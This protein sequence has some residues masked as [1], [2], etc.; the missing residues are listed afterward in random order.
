[1]ATEAN[2]FKAQMSPWRGRSKSRSSAAGAFNFDTDYT[3]GSDFSIYQHF[4]GLKIPEEST[5]VEY[6]WLGGN[7]ELRSKTKTMTKPFDTVADLP[8]WNYDGSS[9]AQAPTEESEVFI[10]PVRIVNDPFRQ[11]RHKL[12]FCETLTPDGTPL[13]GFNNRADAKAIFDQKLETVPWFGIEQEYTLFEADGK[14]PIGFPEVGLPA[15]QGQYYCSVGTG[16]AFGRMVAD[17]HYRAC[18]YAGLTLSGT[19]AEVMPGQWEYQVGPVEGIDSAD[20]LWLSRYIMERV[21]EMFGVRVS[22]DPKPKAGDW[23]G[24]GC[25]TNFSTK[26]MRED[27]GYA[28]IEAACKKLGEKHKELIA[29]YGEG[30]ADRLTGKHETASI[31]KFSYD[32]A[33]RGCSI[34][35]PREAAKEGKGYLED[36]RPAS[37]MDPYLVTS[38]LFATVEGIAWPEEK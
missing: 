20:Q 16:N 13:K 26:A 38:R 31:D 9:T 8:V 30:N 3:H 28:V 4:M 19:N 29:I 36:R 15:A 34:R 23:N 10:R 22:W 5:F 37:N 7:N 24:A 12:V 14:R 32:V 1:M 11:G 17:C 2:D 25:H 18:M 21:C 35:I 6:I 33:N 27:G